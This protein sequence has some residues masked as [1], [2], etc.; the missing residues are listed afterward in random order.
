MERPK[1]GRLVKVRVTDDQFAAL[2]QVANADRSRLGPYVR[3]LLQRHLSE[4]DHQ[5]AGHR[6]VS[7]SP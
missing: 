2:E 6:E 3:T 4:V 5:A 7:V 1:Y